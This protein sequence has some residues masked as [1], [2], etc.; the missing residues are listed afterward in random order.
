MLVGFLRDCKLTQ[1]S[2]QDTLVRLVTGKEKEEV[3]LKRVRSNST[4]VAQRV[5]LGPGRGQVA[6]PVANAVHAGRVP[7]AR[8]R[9]PVPTGI[10]RSSR[11]VAE[12]IQ[13][14]LGL[15]EED[16]QSEME[17]ERD[18][19]AAREYDE[20]DLLVN[21]QEVEAMI[22]IEGSDEEEQEELV[23]MPQVKTKAPRVWPEVATERALRYRREIETIKET[24]QDEVDMY[25]TTMVSEYAEDIFEYMGELEVRLL[26]LLVTFTTN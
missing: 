17:I 25:D 18:D 15:K 24:F 9:V 8:P 20:E 19:E 7:L 23:A 2:F 1:H 21:E 22:G 3:G 12:Q 16:P 14:E 13:E 26:S 5:P 10:K 6:P 11:V 4:T